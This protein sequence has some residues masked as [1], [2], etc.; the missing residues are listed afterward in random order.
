MKKQQKKEQNVES[1]LL[2]IDVNNQLKTLAFCHVAEY[3]QNKGGK[4]KNI[5]KNTSNWS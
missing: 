1:Q 3:A 2:W 5:I 4:K